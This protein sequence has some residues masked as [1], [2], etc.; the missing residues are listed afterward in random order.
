ME[1]GKAACRFY[2]EINE[3]NLTPDTRVVCTLLTGSSEI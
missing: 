1:T 3:I 2:Q